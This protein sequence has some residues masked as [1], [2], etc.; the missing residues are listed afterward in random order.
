MVSRHHRVPSGQ[1]DSSLGRGQVGVRGTCTCACPQHGGTAIA[2]YTRRPAF[3][4]RPV[5]RPYPASVKADRR[6]VRFLI[7]GMRSEL[8]CASTPSWIKGVASDAET[9][10]RAPEN[11]SRFKPHL[12]RLIPHTPTTASAPSTLVFVK[13]YGVDA[14]RTGS[15]FPCAYLAHRLPP[16]SSPRTGKA[17]MHACMSPSRDTSCHQAPGVPRQAVPEW[18]YYTYLQSCRFRA[19]N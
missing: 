16:D 4:E 13:T 10:A 3:D 18:I 11:W 1:C 15:S 14:V 9:W 19:G 12:P 8:N 17:A 5:Q 2:S 6:R 7:R